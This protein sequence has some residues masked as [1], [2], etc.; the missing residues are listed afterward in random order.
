MIKK[1][2]YHDE[3]EKGKEPLQLLSYSFPLF[4]LVALRMQARV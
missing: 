2:Y 1:V 4:A 3:N